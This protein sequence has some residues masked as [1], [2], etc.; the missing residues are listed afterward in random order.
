MLE[1]GQSFE[2]MLSAGL[3]AATAWEL[4]NG[5]LNGT[6]AGQPLG[7]LN[8]PA[9]I[10]I[11]KET[12]QLAA[13]ILYENVAKM[14]SRLH[15]A[16]VATSVWVANSAAIPQMLQMTLGVGTA[17]VFFPV[18]NQNGT[19]GNSLSWCVTLEARA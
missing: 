5:F 10:T 13:T 6:G 9:L 8:D 3:T 17:G 4:D 7:V 2:E 1:D 19:H 15:P 16:C 18:L 14:F 11:T 12:G